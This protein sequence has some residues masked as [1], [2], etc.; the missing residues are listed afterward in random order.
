M[1][2]PGSLGRIP[3]PDD[4]HLVRY[5]LTPATMPTTPVPVCIGI[6]WYENFDAPVPGPGGWAIGAGLLG[7]MRGGHEVVLKP[8]A[9]TDLSAWWR[10]YD[11]GAEGAC[12]GFAHCRM[13]S[14]LNRARYDGLTLYHQAQALD[15]WPGEDYQGTTSRAACEALRTIGPSRVRAGRTLL[16]RAGDGIDVYRWA[17]SVEEIAACLSPEDGGAAILARGY[18]EFL[19]SWGLGYP[20]LTRMPIA[21]L[22]LLVFH[23]DGDAS[24]VTDR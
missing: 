12:E 9:L 15:D 5:A 21:L 24:V 16:P 3:P 2:S 17:T 19:N 6:P 23:Q 13:M 7:R 22:N 1:S 18:V 11:Q 20:H 10:F 4:R 14:L 8:P